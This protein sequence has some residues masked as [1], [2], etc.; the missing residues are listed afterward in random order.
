[1]PRSKPGCPTGRSV[2]ALAYLRVSG[3]GQVDGDGFPRQ[4]DAIA[5]YARA[6]GVELAGEYPATRASA[7]HVTWTTA[8]GSVS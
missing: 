7:A 4:L 2:P 5:R 1:M 8:T 6:H 3:R